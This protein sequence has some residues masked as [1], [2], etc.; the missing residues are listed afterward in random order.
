MDITWFTWMME[1]GRGEIDVDPVDIE[2]EVVLIWSALL[3]PAVLNPI[4]Y[5]CYL[6]EHRRGLAWV[7]R[8]LC[9]CDST[10]NRRREKKAPEDMV[11]MTI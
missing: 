7:A 11:R 5:F 2:I 3:L 1:A 6:G 8:G 9:P 4:V 10:G